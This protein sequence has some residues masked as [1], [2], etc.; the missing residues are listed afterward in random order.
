MQEMIRERRGEDE[1]PGVLELPW[2]ETIHPVGNSAH[3]NKTF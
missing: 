1:L 3:F 2:A